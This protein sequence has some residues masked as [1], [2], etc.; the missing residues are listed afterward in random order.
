[1]AL[2]LPKQ[3]TLFVHIPKT[4]GISIRQAVHSQSSR[5]QLE[6]A[7]VHG[8]ASEAL[9]IL[10]H[11]KMR[12]QN[13]I[14]VVRDP[15]DWAVSMYHFVKESQETEKYREEVGKMDFD[16]FIHWLCAAV[17]A[18]KPFIGGLFRRQSDYL[19]MT[20]STYG[21]WTRAYKFEGLD[22]QW[23]LISNVLGIQT[24]LRKLNESTT[25]KPTAEYWAN[26]ETVSVFVQ[27]FLIDFFN[28]EYPTVAPK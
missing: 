1:M 22:S 27:T 12:V 4:A 20:I 15:F 7:P 2:Y 16:A 9:K 19:S 5:E 24:P 6:V 28:F 26:N 11:R 13:V 18:G 25:R 8:T 21:I 10:A 3:Q 14:A 23:S 17:I